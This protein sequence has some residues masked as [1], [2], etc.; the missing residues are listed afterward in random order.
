[1][2]LRVGKKS[3]RPPAFPFSASGLRGRNFPW[4]A[5]LARVELTLLRD[6]QIN[7][8]PVKVLRVFVSSPGDV[9]RERVL[10]G[11]VL[12]RLQGEFSRQIQL[13]PYFW[14]HEPMLGTMDFQANIPKPSNFDIVICILWSRL[15]SPLN[16]KYRRADGSPYE[17]G[18]EYEFEDASEAHRLS[19]K[20]ELLVYRNRQ[21]PMI[22]IEPEMER[23]E[24]IK[25]FDSLQKFL[26]RWFL[27]PDGTIRIASNDYQDLADFEDKLERNL[28]GLIE[29]IAPTLPGQQ[30][31]AGRPP[32]YAKGSPFRQLRAFEFEDAEIFFGRTKAIDDVLN[33]LRDQAAAGTAFTLIFGSSGSGK[34]SLARAGVLPWV[35]R[36]GVIEGIG[37]WRWAIMRPG[38]SSDVFTGLAA[39]LLGANALPELGAD[40]DATVAELAKA[41][42]E[43]PSGVPLLIKR[44]LAQ[45]ARD[46]QAKKGLPRPPAARLAVLVDQLEEIFTLADRFS[47]ETR[48]R[49]VTALAELARSGVV[50]VV[51]TL[52]SE[53]FGQCEKIPELVALK[54]GKGQVQLL[55]PTVSELRQIVRLPAMA[56]G[57]QFK[58]D[59]D[60][61]RLD[62]RLVDAA[63][64]N[65]GSL[66]L[67]EFALEELYKRREKDI[68][69]THK[70]LDELNGIEGAMESAAE[71]VFK[72]LPAE[73]AAQ[74]EPVFRSL[75][76]TDLGEETAFVRRIADLD[77]LASTPERRRLIDA[78]V[79]GRLLVT[80]SDAANRPIIQVAHEALFLYWPR[81]AAL[82]EDSREFLRRR[83]RAAAA[84]SD[85]L[86]Q[87]RDRSYLWWHGKLLGEAEDLLAHPDD[88]APAEKEFAQESVRA[89]AAAK[90]KRWLARAAVLLIAV[91]AAYAGYLWI[92]KS[93]A[94]AEVDRLRNELRAAPAS[95]SNL[96]ARLSRQLLE[97]KRDDSE[98][99]A[100]YARALLDTN[101]MAGFD[102]A[103]T[104]WKQNVSPLPRKVEDLLGDRDSKQQRNAQAIEHW[105]AYLRDP[106]VDP[107]ERKETWPKMANAAVALG[108]WEQAK[109]Y[110]TQLIKA[111]DHSITARIQRAKVYRELRDW[112][113]ASRDV[114]TAR[115]LDPHDARLKEFPVTFA[116]DK[117]EELGAAIDESPR[118][119]K[120]WQ[121]RATELARLG[122]FKPALEDLEKARGLDSDS[123]RLMLDQ[124]HL[125][126][127][128]QLPIPPELMV[129]PGADWVQWASDQAK[130]SASFEAAQKELGAL[131]ELDAKLQAAPDEAALYLERGALLSRLGQQALA[132]KD[133]QKAKELQPQT[134]PPP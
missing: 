78:F 62:E 119:A 86:E 40:D 83:A 112:N 19:G 85:W 54:S 60:E 2:A 125:L 21:Q 101:N 110:L 102:A 118:E 68:W 12:D 59:K 25:Q 95:D 11:Y 66:P 88:L 77:M 49:F 117:V 7:F 111:Q 67:L 71:G 20:P 80:G 120:R 98:V 121:A 34:S 75:V 23:N 14:E 55:P 79:E 18:T 50:W 57:L 109:D 100:M 133:L 33:A 35:V 24:K 41:L 22:P 84:S 42:R 3:S 94:D 63:G 82:L 74:F 65:P 104:K 37:L 44:S 124:G 8:K 129:R 15:G 31:A 87:K 116:P 114:E 47:P 64:R 93:R 46:S 130:F 56:A 123:V 45:A 99:W 92:Q 96:I 105:K 134:S 108:E 106:D 115:E 38:E 1:M 69:L 4:L 76:T 51:A 9:G 126:W 61:G 73:T 103:M 5:A 48:N 91:A 39:A 107:Q 122:R 32:P 16:E 90:R 30:I 28:R 52:R 127:Q 89:G 13:E 26:R 113:A 10:A 36:P 97:H 72:M 53:F 132:E 58:V 6:F 81:L 131:S 128:L 27:H 43:A 70:A 29:Q 17:S